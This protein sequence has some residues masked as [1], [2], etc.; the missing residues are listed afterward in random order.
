MAHSPPLSVHAWLRYRAIERLLDERKPRT[1]LEIGVGQGSVGVRL[2]IRYD[3]KGVELDDT[4]ILTARARFEHHGLDS[5]RVLHGGLEQVEGQRFDLVC[6][7]EVLEHLEDERAAL[8]DWRGLVAPGGALLVSV[9]AG[10][11]R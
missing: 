9:P 1:V 8:A 7:F 5:S 4:S 2:A 10:P 3:Y 11:S 6:A